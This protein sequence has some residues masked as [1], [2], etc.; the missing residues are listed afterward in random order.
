MGIESGSEQILDN[1]AKH[2]STQKAVRAIDN[3]RQAG[4]YVH[5]NYIIGFPGETQET[6]RET[7]NFMKRTQA[8]LIH[9]AGVPGAR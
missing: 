2:I 4:L 1:M 5:A 6:A 9:P 7:I 3:L 8:D